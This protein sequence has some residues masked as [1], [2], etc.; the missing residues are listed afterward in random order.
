MSV[1]DQENYVSGDRSGRLCDFCNESKA[2]LYCRAD[3]ARLCF[4]CDREVHST[5]PLFKKHN[6]SLLCDSCN[7][8]PSSIFCCTESAVL[9]QNCDW[10]NHNNFKSIH[11][12][13]PIEGFNGCPSVS[14]LLSFLGL[15]DLGKKSLVFDGG[16]MRGFWICW[17]G[18]LLRFTRGCW[19]CTLWF[20]LFLW[21]MCEIL[22]V[23]FGFAVVELVKEFLFSQKNR[24]LGYISLVLIIS[25][26]R[27]RNA[28]C[29]KH[30][31]EILCQLREMAKA[32]PNFG[33]SME[34]LDPVEFQSLVP[35]KCQLRDSSP[36]PE[37]NAEP[38]LVPSYETSA[39][40]WF[41]FTGAVEDKGFPSTFVGSFNE[42]SHLVPDKDSD[43][44]D[45]TGI[46]HGLQEVQSSIPVDS[47]SFQGLP[48]S[49]A[50]ELN[51][52]ERDSALSR[53]KEKRKTRRYD[54][55]I[56][57]E[58]R[59]VR[60][61]TTGR[62]TVLW[63]V[64]DL[65]F[66]FQGSA[67]MMHAPMYLSMRWV[68]EIRISGSCGIKNQG[69]AKSSKTMLWQV[70]LPWRWKTILSEAR[71]VSYSKPVFILPLW[72]AAHNSTI[73]LLFGGDIRQ[74]KG[75]KAT[76]REDFCSKEQRSS[77]CIVDSRCT[78]S[79][80][81][82]PVYEKLKEMLVKNH[83]LRYKETRNQGI[84]SLCYLFPTETEL[85]DLPNISFHLQDADLVF[86]PQVGYIVDRT[87]FGRNYI[88]LGM[89][90]GISM[91]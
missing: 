32:E 64:A 62:H 54:K 68:R 11:D 38:I 88:C 44:G 21:F 74:R 39:L 13:R 71:T 5:N 20:V 53:Y 28:A 87:R 33:G 47:K 86:P 42:M 45:S 58:S 84:Q 51:T 37:S 15:E 55:H 89:S 23:V 67:L 50:R 35:G 29:G 26:N 2:L 85:K 12:R 56:R 4:N 52:Q 61:E 31:E 63:H 83:F 48:I 7:S 90:S 16:T 18:R 80:M 59:K 57:Y 43:V 72:D 65:R 49:G 27:N 6:R 40:N 81:P 14:E 10:E 34:E 76:I 25:S 30:K 77:G 82:P 22:E 19:D 78:L 79:M 1:P 17:F 41:D 3:S 8:S 36:G 46:A 73:F 69:S 70:T 60:A 75:L 66:D 24:A 91:A 9:C